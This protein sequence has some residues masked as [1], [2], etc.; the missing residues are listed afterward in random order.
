MKT[1]HGRFRGYMIHLLIVF[2]LQASR[3]ARYR[4]TGSQINLNALK[5]TRIGRPD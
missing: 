4:A 5:Q 2:S 1:F 3:K